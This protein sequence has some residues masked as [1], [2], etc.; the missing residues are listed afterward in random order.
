MLFLYKC[1]LFEFSWALLALGD[2][3]RMEELPNALIF[4]TEVGVK[5]VWIKWLSIRGATWFLFIVIVNF[6]A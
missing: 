1:N 4:F 6:W 5:A 3:L 2:C